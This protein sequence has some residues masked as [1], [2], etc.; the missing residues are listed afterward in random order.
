VPG[1]PELS[2]SLVVLPVLGG[3]AAHAPLLVFDL[4]PRARRPISRRLFGE[5]KTWRGAAAMHGGTLAATVLLH[6]VPG[7]RRRL[8]PAVAAAHPLRVGALLGLSLWLGELPNSFL[9]RRLGIPP[10][11]R[12]RS[13]LGAAFSVVD[14][15]DWVLTAWVLL[16]PIWP[17]TT[18]EAAAVFGTVTAVHLPLNVIGYAVGARSAPI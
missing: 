12:R 3:A 10:G 5:N 17:M 4:L 16:R 6:Q 7:Y 18:R 8:P 11:Q 2:A 14:Q 1:R 9:K 15:A 13:A